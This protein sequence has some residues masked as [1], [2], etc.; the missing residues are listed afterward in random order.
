MNT[1]RCETFNDTFVRGVSKAS[2]K[3]AVVTFPFSFMF[4]FGTIFPANG[5]FGGG[6]VQ[7]KQAV[8]QF[9]EAP[10]VSISLYRLWSYRRGNLVSCHEPVNVF[11]KQTRW[12]TELTTA[13]NPLLPQRNP[14]GNGWDCTRVTCKISLHR[15]CGCFK[16]NLL[17]TWLTHVYGIIY[18]INVTETLKGYVTTTAIFSFL[19][20]TCS[21]KQTN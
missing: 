3:C 20:K 6:V 14:T 5:W 13:P 7:G 2:C 9:M 1:F 12:C 15:P 21:E 10:Q 4:P 18:D 8:R 16:G 17:Y 11:C 19:G